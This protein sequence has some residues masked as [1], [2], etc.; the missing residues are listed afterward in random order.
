[1]LIEEA[2]AGDAALTLSSECGDHQSWAPLCPAARILTQSLHSAL[3]SLVIKARFAFGKSGLSR[4]K[5]SAFCI[6]VCG[7]DFDLLKLNFELSH[8][9]WL[10]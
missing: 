9:Q 8:F 1:M 3:R 6:S 2:A 10:L 4:S 7:V 5:S